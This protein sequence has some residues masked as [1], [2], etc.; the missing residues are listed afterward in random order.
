MEIYGINKGFFN[1]IN[2]N[3]EKV[4]QWYIKKINYI[5]NIILFNLIEE[6]NKKRRIN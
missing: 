5:L 4:I 1:K 3:V 2:E 6:K